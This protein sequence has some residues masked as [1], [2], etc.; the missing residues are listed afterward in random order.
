[1]KMKYLLLA[2]VLIGGTS[3]AQETKDPDTLLDYVKTACQA[4]LDKFCSQVT[5]GEGRMLYCVAAHQD[6]ISDQCEGALVDAA[7]ILADVTD[8]VVSAAEACGP[9][10]EKYCGDV[11]V[12]EGRVL[13]CLDEVA[14]K[15]DTC[16][17]AVN[18]LTDPDDATE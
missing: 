8:R 12:G 3:S 18:D 17:A 15:S 2:A 1:M 9:E 5:P 10:L 7:M 16:E 11:E 14:E 13:A 6:K 4:D